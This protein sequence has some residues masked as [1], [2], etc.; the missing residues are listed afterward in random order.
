MFR[1]ISSKLPTSLTKQKDPILTVDDS[2]LKIAVD[3]KVTDVLP[4]V[5]V[6]L[7][8][9][10]ED[11]P[12]T[13]PE[14]L[15]PF[16]RSFEFVMTNDKLIAK[17]L[18][19]QPFLEKCHSILDLIKTCSELDINRLLIKDVR[20]THLEVFMFILKNNIKKRTINAI[21]TTDTSVYDVLISK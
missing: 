10:L 13:F 3:G 17:H 20:V 19:E 9:S 5:K 2:I 8:P 7:Y 15:K 12:V 18:S 6:P 16:C 14:I 11:R 21:M 4:S 1:V